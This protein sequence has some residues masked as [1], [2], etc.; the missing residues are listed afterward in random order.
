MSYGISKVALSSFSKH[1]FLLIHQ[2][3]FTFCFRTNMP[4]SKIPLMRG[5]MLIYEGA[6]APQNNVITHMLYNVVE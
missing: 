4:I 5:D 6:V 1:I 3:L 2:D